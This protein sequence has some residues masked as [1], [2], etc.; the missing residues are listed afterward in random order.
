MPKWSQNRFK[1]YKNVVKSRCKNRCKTAPPKGGSAP[2]ASAP[3]V[4]LS[5]HTL[6]LF[7]SIIYQTSTQPSKRPAGT[8]T[9]MRGRIYVASDNRPRMLWLVYQK[10]QNRVWNTRFSCKLHPGWSQRAPK[11]S[12]RAPKGSQRTPKWNQNQSK[13]YQNCSKTDTSAKV[14]FGWPKWH[15]NGS[16]ME[17]KGLQNLCIIALKIDATINAEKVLE[18]EAKMKQN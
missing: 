10:R 13:I 17:R 14:D 4:V 6:Y 2:E 11:G 7:L 5:R 12:Q 1:S 18:N 15:Q 9:R 3:L 16:K 8:A